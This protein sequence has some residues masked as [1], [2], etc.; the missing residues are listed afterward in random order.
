V[1]C[2]TGTGVGKTTVAA[3]LL[4]A[5]RAAGHRVGARK[6]VQSFD[7]KGPEA[8]DAVVLGRASG[9]AAGEVCPPERTYPLAMA[10]PIAAAALG[11]P[12]VRL[13]E[14]VE[15]VRFPDGLDV[16]LVEAV[17]GVRSPIAADAESLD[18]VGALDPHLVLLVADAGLGTLNAVRLSWAALAGATRSP[19]TVVLNRFDPDERLHAAN[20]SWLGGRDR[21]DVVVW[22]GERD[23]LGALALGHPGAPDG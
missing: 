15:A 1:V 11:L 22:P 12:P 10:P 2:G 13:A 6:P 9:E 5:L 18:L 8:P 3:G 19:C 14:L 4:G 20:R 17:G 16:G 23:R 7:P 21:L